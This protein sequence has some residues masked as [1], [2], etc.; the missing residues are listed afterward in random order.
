[1][2]IK[3]VPINTKY[4]YQLMISNCK[5]ANDNNIK[6]LEDINKELKILYEDIKDRVDVYKKEFDIDITKYEE[7]KSNKYITGEFFR[8]TKGLLINKKGNYELKG[9]LFDLY[10]LAKTQKVIN[11]IERE[12]KFNEKL[13][14]IEYKDYNKLIKT[15]YTEVQRQ[16]ILEG[17]AYHFEGALGMIF[18]NRCK[19][20]KRKPTIDYAATKKR[21]AELAAQGKRI[22]NK[23]EAEWCKER[24]INYDG[25]DG[26]VYQDIEYIYEIP[27]VNCRLQNCK[28]AK[29]TPTDYISAKF[30]G[31]TYNDI[32]E[33][34]HHNINEICN[35]NLDIKKKLKL[36]NEVNKILYTK[37]IRHENQESYKFAKSRS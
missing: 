37:Y 22:Y 5:K 15:Y 2:A 30:R 4:Y 28:D 6:K 3:E 12:I 16:L 1:M 13:I 35:A 33:A 25:I 36:C 23:E 10:N 19:V 11:N 21:K 31:K 14:N 9:D 32:I 27:L 24:N 26:R 17:N 8:V 29:F 18:I 34:C 7:F 20:R